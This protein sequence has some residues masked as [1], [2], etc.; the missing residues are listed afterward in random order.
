MVPETKELKKA[1]TWLL[2]A[3]TGSFVVLARIVAT[4]EHKKT[5]PIFLVTDQDTATQTGT[6]GRKLSNHN[7]FRKQKPFL[8]FFFAN[9]PIKFKIQISNR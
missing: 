6:L 5:C 3:K 7:V 8:K 2:G 4:G 9:R 1:K